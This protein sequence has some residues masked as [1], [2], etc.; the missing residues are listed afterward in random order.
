MSPNSSWTRPGLQHNRPVVR[1]QEVLL[2]AFAG[3]QFLFQSF[4]TSF[5]HGRG[6]NRAEYRE[7]QWQHEQRALTSEHNAWA[8]LVQE[9]I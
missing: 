6:E 3:H 1:V 5:V 4:I 8:S 9:F 7:G 2:N